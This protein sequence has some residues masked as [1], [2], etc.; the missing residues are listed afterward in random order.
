MTQNTYHLA[1][2]NIARFIKPMDDPANVDFVNNIERINALAEAQSDFIWRFTQSTPELEFAVFGHA[3]VIST[4]SL[5]SSIK[6]LSEF[7]YHNAEHRKIMRRRNE[8]FE[9]LEVSVVL[10]WVKAGH[11]PNLVEAKKRLD[12]LQREGATAEAFSFKNPFPAPS[13]KNS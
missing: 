1:E 12:Q 7:V 8:W 9:H 5:W 3:H 11:R 13:Q 4:L 6:A 2:L 10:W